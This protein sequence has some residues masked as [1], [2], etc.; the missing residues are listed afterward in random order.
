VLFDDCGHM[1]MM[2]QPDATAASLDAFVRSSP[3]PR[4]GSQTLA[5]R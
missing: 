3:R 5:R 4:P 2:Q 1:P